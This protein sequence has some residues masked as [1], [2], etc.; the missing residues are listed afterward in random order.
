LNG[1]TLLQN[2]DYDNKS[3]LLIVKCLIIRI[4]TNTLPN[5]SEN[6]SS[7][8]NFSLLDK[9]CFLFTIIKN[10]SSSYIR[11][12]YVNMNLASDF[13]ATNLLTYD[14][15]VLRPLLNG[16]ISMEN[17][18]SSRYLCRD[19]SSEFMVQ[20]KLTFFFKMDLKPSVIRGQNNKPFIFT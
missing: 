12:M 11:L 6:L 14:Q 4:Y 16:Y 7:G 5:S 17:R 2:A 15:Y 20:G 10:H 3:N 13:S 8:L 9:K 1:S 18:A 19:F